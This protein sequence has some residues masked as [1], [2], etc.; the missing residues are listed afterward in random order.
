MVY[1]S[2]KATLAALAIVI[3]A[4]VGGAR[5]QP[6]E[7]PE[8]FYYEADYGELT[9]AEQEAWAALGWTAENWDTAEATD[10]PE[11]EF[12]QWA[13]LSEE[14]RTALTSLGY[15]ETVWNETRPRRPET[16]VED[17]WNSL[18]WQDL[19]PREQA[20]WGALGWDEATWSKQAEA[21]ASEAMRWAELA[22]DQRLAAERLG[23]AED[24]WDATVPQ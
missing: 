14:Q 21:P 10:D 13:D 6:Y 1:G 8:E 24:T 19:R 16:G 9:A 17:F 23:Y 4:G 11:S 12:T 22:D 18:Q 15:D 5:A 20:L 7:N 2:M 3:L